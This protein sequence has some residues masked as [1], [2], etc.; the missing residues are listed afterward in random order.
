MIIVLTLRRQR[1]NST[2]SALSQPLFG[3]PSNGKRAQPSHSESLAGNQGATYYDQPEDSDS[4]TQANHTRHR[5]QTRSRTLS[6]P[7]CGITGESDGLPLYRYGGFMPENLALDLEAAKGLNASESRS[8]YKVCR[9]GTTTCRQRPANVQSS[10]S[11]RSTKYTL[12]HHH[13]PPT[14]TNPKRKGVLHT[15]TSL[16]VQRTNL[17][18]SLSRFPLRPP[19]Q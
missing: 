16:L 8:K 1:K 3:V 10:L 17:R 11:Q 6:Q 7:L 13:T 12:H 4:D 2:V 9:T 14:V 19:V 15:T 5:S 18:R